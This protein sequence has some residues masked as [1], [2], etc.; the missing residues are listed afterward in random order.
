MFLLK[1]TKKPDV[2]GFKITNCSKTKTVGVA[3]TSL[4]DLLRKACNKFQFSPSDANLYLNDGTLIDS[5]DYFRTIPA[6]TVLTL[7]NKDDKITTGADLIYNAL[8]TLNVQFLTAGRLAEEF[9]Q[10]DIKQKIRVLSDVVNSQD[11]EESF[12]DWLKGVETSCKSKDGFMESRCKDRIKSYF[13]KACNDIKCSPRYK[14][15]SKP[16]NSLLKELK[17]NLSRRNYQGAYFNRSKRDEA[18]CDAVGLF[19]C[20]GLW[21]KPVCDLCNGQGHVINPYLSR[22]TRIVF[23]TWNLDHR[24]ER[25][26]T[27]VPS[28]LDAVELLK[29]DSSCLN[30]DRIYELLFTTANLKLVHVVCHDK[31]AHVGATC[32]P[33]ELIVHSR[34]LPKRFKGSPEK[35]GNLVDS[36][37]S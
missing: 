21:S 13:Y 4:D 3:C 34:P 27:I 28:I 25:S 30:V 26:R 2:K 14:T 5:E 35:C 10:E 17:I 22:E 18:L 37:A 6:Q 29:D 33:K 12:E 19:K 16:L 32:S 15:H 20:Q 23:S 9:L 11:T 8:K 1:L 31:G 24:I 7:A 36:R